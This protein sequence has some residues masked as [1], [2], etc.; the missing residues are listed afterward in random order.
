MVGTRL[1]LFVLTLAGFVAAPTPAL[2]EL[3]ATRDLLE[4]LGFS[5]D[6]IGRIQHGELLTRPEQPSSERELTA[7]FAFFVPVA[8]ADLAKQARQGLLDRVDENTLAFAM[9]PGTPSLA[10]FTK[11]TLAPDPAQQAQLYVSATPGGGLNLSSAEIARFAALGSGSGPAAVE[12]AVRGALL[13]RLEAY[14]A[15]GLAGI[16]PYALSDGK[17]R[18][19][20][21]E[22]RSASQAS[23]NLEKYVPAAYQMLLAYP[24]SKAPGTEET[25]RWTRFMAHGVPTVS[26]THGLAIPEG[27]AWLLVQRQFY[28]S[29]GYNAEQA[30]A[31]LLPAQGGTVVVYSNRTSTDQV[32]GWGGSAKRSIGSSLLASQLEELFRKASTAAQ[33]GAKP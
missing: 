9:I 30:I 21:D 22:L 32:T 13:A 33:K 1:A 29:T 23:K 7:A 12:P 15:K 31:A 14:R 6:E 25:F 5:P 8:P 4:Q 24:T 20:G 18:S 16:E 10:S 3:P 11:L 17:Q 28:V 26:L 2:A 27:D 19:A